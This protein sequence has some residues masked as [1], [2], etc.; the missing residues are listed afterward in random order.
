[1]LSFRANFMYVDERMVPTG[2]PGVFIPLTTNLNSILLL[3]VVS[4]LQSQK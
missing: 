1:M 4:N 2:F 3:R